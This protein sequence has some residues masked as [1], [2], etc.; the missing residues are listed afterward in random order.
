MQPAHRGML[1]V[2]TEPAKMIAA[3]QAYEAPVV[4]KWIARGQS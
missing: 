3:M 2:E 1:I 4:T